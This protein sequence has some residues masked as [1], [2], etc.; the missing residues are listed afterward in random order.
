MQ[1]KIGSDYIPQYPITGHAGNVIKNSDIDEDNTDFIISLYKCF[2][3]L[4]DVNQKGV[5]TPINFAINNR[6]YDP[7]NQANELTV[8]ELRTLQG[9]ASDAT[10]PATYKQNISYNIDT[11]W[12][13]PLFHEN[14]CV[15]KALY[16]IRLES[17]HD[18]DNLTGTNTTRIRPIELILKN[19]ASNTYQRD[20]TMFIFMYHDFYVVY[21][22]PENGGTNTFGSG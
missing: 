20:S 1:L 13:L 21:K 17:C 5:I 16:S 12:G 4:F 14:R 7:A 18:P 10:A 6:P 8:A 3:H 22:T 19:D 15:G 2:N 11:G 9:W